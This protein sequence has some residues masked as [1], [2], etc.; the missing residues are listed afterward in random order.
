[1]VHFVK[2]SKAYNTSS[3]TKALGYTHERLKQGPEGGK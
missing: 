2:D 3:L 1:M